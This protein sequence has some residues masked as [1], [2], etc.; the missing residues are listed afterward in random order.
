VG[1]AS[2]RQA[3]RQAGKRW[4]RRWCLLRPQAARP[5]TEG[6]QREGQSPAERLNLATAHSQEVVCLS[7]PYSSGY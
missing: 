1:L 5:G 6:E 4:L 7:S 2:E 3:G